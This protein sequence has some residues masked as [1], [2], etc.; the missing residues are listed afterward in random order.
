MCSPTRARSKLSSQI[1]G[2]S[3]TTPLGVAAPG[4][5]DQRLLRGDG[6]L[7]QQLPGV[8]RCLRVPRLHPPSR[9][10]QS[11]VGVRTVPGRGHPPADGNGR[12]DRLHKAGGRSRSCVCNPGRR[13]GEKDDVYRIPDTEQIP[14]R[15][16]RKLMLARPHIVKGRVHSE[17][18][19]RERTCPPRWGGSQQQH[20]PPLHAHWKSGAQ[21]AASRALRE[22]TSR[23]QIE[24]SLKL[25]VVQGYWNVVQ[26]DGV[27][28]PE[29][30]ESTRPHVKTCSQMVAV[31]ALLTAQ[32]WRQ[33]RVSRQTS[34]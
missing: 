18:S 1:V 34:G 30:I 25:N 8:G 13:L 16:K 11:T 24:R 2:I 20:G 19:R 21:A 17:G 23:R 22:R 14:R 29:R 10:E 12:E 5:L 6:G 4:S 28:T 7:G 32:Q 33:P 26:G 31:V 27:R 3:H 9:D 15:S